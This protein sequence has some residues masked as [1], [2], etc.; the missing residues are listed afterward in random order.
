VVWLL[1]LAF[2]AARRPAS[3]DEVSTSVTMPRQYAQAATP[4]ERAEIGTAATLAPFGTMTAIIVWRTPE[5]M[6]DGI[7]LARANA[8]AIEVY[9]LVSC[10]AEPGAKVVIVDHGGMGQALRDQRHRRSPC[11]LPRRRAEPEREALAA[12]SW[13]AV[14]RH[15]IL[16]PCPGSRG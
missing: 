10:I 2:P 9:P 12:P 4:A 11:G 3:A 15:R 6:Q 5:A 13:R 14:V 16:P 1:A 8:P 7:A